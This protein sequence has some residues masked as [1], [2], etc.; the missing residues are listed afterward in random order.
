MNN[1]NLQRATSEAKRRWD[2]ADRPDTYQTVIT[3]AEDGQKTKLTATTEHRETHPMGS[4][5]YRLN[6]RTNG[7]ETEPNHP[8]RHSETFTAVTGVIYPPALQI[9]TPRA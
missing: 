3:V 4:A 9:S 1:A 6:L 8:N 7:T 5:T 2:R